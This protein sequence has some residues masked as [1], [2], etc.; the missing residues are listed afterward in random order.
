M[1]SSWIGAIESNQVEMKRQDAKLLESC[2]TQAQD[3]ELLN[4]T[5]EMFMMKLLV[6]QVTP[7]PMLDLL[8]TTTSN[9]K[10]H[11]RVNNS[12]LTTIVLANLRFGSIW[13]HLVACNY[14]LSAMFSESS[15]VKLWMVKAT[16]RCWCQ[17]KMMIPNN[18]Y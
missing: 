18:V 14:Q 10:V 17:M 8:V 12:N 15:W 3:I 16:P 2:D 1:L 7:H 11:D 4:A 6:H 9:G 13:Q 5:I